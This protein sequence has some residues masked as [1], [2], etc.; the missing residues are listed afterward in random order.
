M[1]IT[2]AVPLISILGYHRLLAGRLHRAEV[3]VVLAVAQAKARLHL[4]AV[5]CPRQAGVLVVAHCLHQA[6]ILVAV[7]LALAVQAKQAV[8]V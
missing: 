3:P 1:T 8:A 7:L 2:A 4:V 5:H 6:G